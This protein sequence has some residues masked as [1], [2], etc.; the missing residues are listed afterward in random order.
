MVNTVDYF[1]LRGK[2]ML[3]QVTVKYKQMIF[4][5]QFLSI[6][7]YSNSTLK[8]LAWT[9]SFVEGLRFKILA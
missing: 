7:F 1:G 8:M 5:Q 4:I 3:C 2:K 9:G 6:L